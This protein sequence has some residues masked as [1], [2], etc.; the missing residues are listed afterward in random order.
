MQHIQRLKARH[1]GAAAQLRGEKVKGAAARD[2][3]HMTRQDQ[4]LDA[5]A[6]S[7]KQLPE[8]RRHQLVQRENAQVLQASGF[9]FQ[10]QQGRARGG[11]FKSRGRKDHLLLLVLPGQLQHIQ[12]RVNQADPGPPGLLLQ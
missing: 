2:R 8:R 6:S 9:R 4:A 12:G 1:H 11:G 5:A 3:A 7:R 10:N